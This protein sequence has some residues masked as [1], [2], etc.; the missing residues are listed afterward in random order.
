VVSLTKN[1]D[2]ENLQEVRGS[3]M[4]SLGRRIDQE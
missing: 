4:N 3:P 1:Y 2:P